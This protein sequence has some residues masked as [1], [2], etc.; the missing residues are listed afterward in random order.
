MQNFMELNMKKFTV[1]KT[2]TFGAWGLITSLEQ[3]GHKAFGRGLIKPLVKNPG[4]NFL[5][6]LTFSIIMRLIQ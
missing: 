6:V 4:S 2:L 1:P 3:F 5:Q